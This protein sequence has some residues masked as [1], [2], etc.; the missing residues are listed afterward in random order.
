MCFPEWGSDGFFDGDF[1]LETGDF[2]SLC[3][4]SVESHFGVLGSVEYLFL[5]DFFW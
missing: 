5:G 3:C 1:A 4:F 2:D